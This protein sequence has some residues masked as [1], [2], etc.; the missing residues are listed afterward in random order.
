MSSF[1]TD[2]EFKKRREAPE[3]NLQRAVW[4]HIKL[5]A[6]PDVIAF[7]VPNGSPKSKRTGARFKAQGLVPG[8]ADLCFVLTDG[9]AAFLELKSAKGRMSPEQRSFASKCERMKVPFAVANN[10]DD[11]LSILRGWGVFDKAPADGGR[12]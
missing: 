8:I 1:V 5:L 4:Q 3:E 12:R 11:A 6:R 10:I 2:V 7:A 9:S